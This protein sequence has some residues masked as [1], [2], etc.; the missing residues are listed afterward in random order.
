MRKLKIVVATLL[1]TLVITVPVA[2]YVVPVWDVPNGVAQWMTEVQTFVSMLK[3]I[4]AVYQRV[5][6]LYNQYL[7]VTAEYRQLKN[8]Q[9]NGTWNN[10]I[11]VY[12]SIEGVLNQADHLGYQTAGLQSLLNETYPGLLLPSDWPT[13]YRRQ[14]TRGIAT[15]KDLVNVL[16]HISRQN[17]K[18]QLRLIQIQNRI[19]NSDGA[20]QVIQAQAMLTSLAAEDA[21]RNLQATLTAANISGLQHVHELQKEADAQMIVEGQLA[22]PKLIGGLTDV[23]TGVPASWPW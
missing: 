13:E 21:G 3:D 4:Y 11:G 16:D 20:V 2:A 5:Q 18:S 10:L 22:T 8:W 6:M 23:Y 12:G 1:L 15:T 19:G 17:I 9:H 14:L 7:Q